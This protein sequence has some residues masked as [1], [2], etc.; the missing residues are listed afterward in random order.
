MVKAKKVKHFRVNPVEVGVFIIVAMIFINSV[1]HLFYDWKGFEPQKISFTDSFKDRSPASVGISKHESLMKSSTKSNFEN[2]E[3]GCASKL[4][5]ET[6]APR[7]RLN[8]PLC[9]H[10]A[11]KT[12]TSFVKT[13]ITNNANK[14]QA[15]VFSDVTEGTY[16]TDYIFLN[17]GENPLTIRFHY[18]LGSETKTVTQDLL[19]TKK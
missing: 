16:L 18:K 3:I 4:V 6:L 9:G 14:S 12:N 7:V 15:T 8:G 10:E 11:G 1:Y 17:Q 5:Q 2:I 19:L 13:E